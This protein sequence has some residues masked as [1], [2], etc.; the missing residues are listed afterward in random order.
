MSKE[1]RHLSPSVGKKVDLQHSQRKQS[2]KL[3]QV[4]ELVVWMGMRTAGSKPRMLKIQILG[5]A[6][7]SPEETNRAYGW[8]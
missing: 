2:E 3:T 1:D 5:H 4:Q 6:T 7:V 8:E